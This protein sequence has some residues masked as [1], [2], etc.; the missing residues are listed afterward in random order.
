MR[1]VA[2]II[3]L[4]LVLVGSVCLLQGIRVV[5][6]EIRWAVYGAIAVAVGVGVLFVAKKRTLSGWMVLSSEDLLA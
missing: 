2:N 5:T 1:T 6:H 3:G 4:I